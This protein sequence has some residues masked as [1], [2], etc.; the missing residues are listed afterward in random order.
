M[1]IKPTVGYGITYTTDDVAYD[2]VGKALEVGYR[3][4]NTC[5]AYENEQGIGKALLA[6]CIPRSE[7]T[8]VA[9]D[10]NSKR[11]SKNPV[12]FD[13]YKAQINQIENSLSI[14]KMDYIDIYLIHWPV[15][16]YMEGQWR[17]LNSDSWRAMEDCVHK[18]MIKHIGVSNFLPYHI[19]VLQQTAKMPIEVNQL[20]IHPNFQQK[21]TVDYCRK[22]GM[23]IMSWSPLFKGK[24]VCLPCILDLASKYNKTPAQIILRWNLQKGIAPVVCSTNVDRMRSNYDVFDFHIEESDIRLID[25]LETGEHVEAFSYVR[26]KESLKDVSGCE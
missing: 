19:K 22:Q 2:A 4:I 18:G 11:S 6:S 24:A 14:L 8:I 16:R 13:G 20:E 23:D 9:L 3:L 10:S 26:Q 15:P 25:A 12:N 7:L 21:E 1:L 5:S 17:R